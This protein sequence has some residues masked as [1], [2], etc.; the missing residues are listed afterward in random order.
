MEVL[1]ENKTLRGQIQDQA[2]KI[3][4]ASDPRTYAWLGTRD[5]QNWQ[6]STWGRVIVR[7][8]TDDDDDAS[9]D[10]GSLSDGQLEQLLQRKIEQATY[11]ASTRT[12]A[13]I[14]REMQI[15]E[16]LRTV[17]DSYGDI[18]YD[19]SMAPALRD[20]MRV[21]PQATGE[22]ALFAT[23]PGLVRQALR[24]GTRRG[25]PSGMSP[26]GRRSGS[27]APAMPRSSG[28]HPVEEALASGDEVAYKASLEQLLLSLNPME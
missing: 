7:A 15:A 19:D 10:I 1:E 6:R 9:D 13:R 12:E 27:A 23:Q 22:Q 8:A 21:H 24:N 25:A 2:Q 18:G 3:N 4:Q 28:K 26:G 16:E 20:Y 11:E 14:T 17:E 5:G